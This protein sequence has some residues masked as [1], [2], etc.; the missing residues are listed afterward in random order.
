M[1]KEIWRKDSEEEEEKEEIILRSSKK[2]T[3]M[4]V[5]LKAQEILK[6]VKTI[7]SK[8]ND[9][10]K[11]RKQEWCIRMPLRWMVRCYWIEKVKWIT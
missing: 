6:L 4:S 10:Y 5:R 2:Y 3:E 9:S 7:T 11:L 1:W 8:K